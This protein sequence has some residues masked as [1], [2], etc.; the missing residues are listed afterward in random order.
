MASSPRLTGRACPAE[1][2][3]ALAELP[4]RLRLLYLQMLSYW[5]RH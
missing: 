2:H 1:L 3:L 4:S 5:L